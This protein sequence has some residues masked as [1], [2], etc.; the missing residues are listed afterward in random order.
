MT[1]MREATIIRDT[2][3]T[4]IR[5]Y[6]ALEGGESSISTGC[7][8]L[9]HMLELFAGH[10]GF[11]LAVECHGDTHVD[12]HHTVED[13]GIALG[14]ALH[15]ALGDKRGIVRYGNIILPMDEALMLVAVDISGRAHLEYDVPVPSQKVGDFDTELAEEFMQALV[16]S[17]GLTLHCRK[18]AGRNTHHIIEALFKALG[19]V[20]KQA[21][22]IDPLAADKIPSTKG[23]I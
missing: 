17:A 6:L 8:F 19:R 7:G 16:R 18:L 22:A 14:E 10:S 13:V 3:E 23:I 2:R 12:Y 1:V 5:L 20:L 11:G 15:Q 21:V 9:D 4:Q